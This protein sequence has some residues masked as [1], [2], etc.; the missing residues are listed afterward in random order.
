MQPWLCP[1]H[2]PSAVRAGPGFP[3][4]GKPTPAI[5]AEA[6]LSPRKNR[7][8]AEV[9]WRPSPTSEAAPGVQGVMGLC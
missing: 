1:K 5:L 9:P 2:T 4:R 6:P 8:E 7:G 3:E